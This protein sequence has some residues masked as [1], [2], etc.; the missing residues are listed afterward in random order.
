MNYFSNL[1]FKAQGVDVSETDIAIAKIRF[2]HISSRFTV[3]EAKPRDNEYYGFPENVSVV[4]A[5]QSLYYFAAADFADAMELI[6]GSMRRGGVFFASMMGEQSREFFD[7]SREA[8]GGLREVNFKNQRLEVKGYY[9]FFIRD[10]EHLRQKFSMFK[11]AHIGY[12]AA[13]LR[14]DEGDGFHYTFCGVKE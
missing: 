9:M 1:G 5:F 11:P 2:P 13:K 12:Y 4:T 6:Y 3:C 10:E 7:A 8:E 14:N